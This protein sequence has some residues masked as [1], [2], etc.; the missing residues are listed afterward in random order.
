M[1]PVDIFAIAAAIVIA[2]LSLIVEPWSGPWWTALISAGFIAVA[3]LLHMT[4]GGN[5]NRIVKLTTIVFLL[6][7]GPSFA[8][9]YWSHYPA[10]AKIMTAW[11]PP[12]TAV[13]PPP[14]ITPAPQAPARTTE[15]TAERAIYKCK[16]P[17]AID[18][19]TAD[20]R[21][22]EFKKYIEVYADTFGYAS[23]V[24]AVPGGSKAELTPATALGQKNLGSAL[25]VTF[26]VRTIGKDLLGI[27]TAEYPP[28]LWAG[29]LLPQGSD[30]EKRIRKRIEDLVGA[31]QGGCELQ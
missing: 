28:T 12:P 25:K 5:A 31:E 3:A 18:Q 1:R 10:S 6:V 20:A 9:W 8:Y 30:P 24:S 15:A 16:R 17:E 2:L 4:L 7:G 19:K 11:F 29:Y 21:F 27:Y 14:K 23:K 13:A 26:E 22:V